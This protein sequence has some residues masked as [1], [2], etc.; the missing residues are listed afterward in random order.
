[1]ADFSYLCKPTI[2]TFIMNKLIALVMTL[3][4]VTTAAAQNAKDARIKEIRAAYSQ[5]KKRIE[6]NGKGGKSPK[7]MTIMFNQLEDKDIP[8]Y[9]EESINYYFD[10]TYPEG[11]SV[12]HPYFIV[13]NWTCH[14]HT[15]YREI[16]LNPQDQQVMF[17]YMKGETDGGFVV[18]SRYYYDT[19]GKCI[20]QKHNTDNTWTDSGSE[21]ENA[22]YY[23]K[24]FNMA[25]HNG[26]FSPLDTDTKAKPT[27]PKAKRIA[28]IRSIYAQAKDKIAKN[29]K[30]EMPNDLHITI[31]DLGDNEPPRTQEIRMYFDTACYFISSQ[32][33]SMSLDGYSEYLFDPKGESLIF[34][35]T[36]GREEGNEYEWRYYY[37][38]NGKCIETKSNSEET[39][40]GF[41]DKR[42]AKDYQAIFSTLLNEGQE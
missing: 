38:E 22:E 35:Y 34:S 17:C 42:A 33:T 2:R 16:L 39:D 9:N 32:S 25:T 19:K 5:A 30:A 13:E 6:Q 24:L 23:L 15:R 11:I 26:Y 10:E 28:Q 8:L 12:K 14:G 21:K 29:D 37:D 40:D 41:Y 20:E 27:T 31:H 7:D 4:V 1:M 3:L 18:E 36:R